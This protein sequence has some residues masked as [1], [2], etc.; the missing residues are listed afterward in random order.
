M[1]SLVYSVAEPAGSVGAAGAAGTVAI[2]GTVVP[3]WLRRPSCHHNL[4]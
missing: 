3:S 4:P 1:M 2:A